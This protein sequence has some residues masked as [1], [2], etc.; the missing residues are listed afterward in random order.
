MSQHFFADFGCGCIGQTLN[1]PST[2]LNFGWSFFMSYS[3][4]C[5]VPGWMF[6]QLWSLCLFNL[7]KIV[8]GNGKKA[9]NLGVWYRRSLIILFWIHILCS[10]YL[11]HKERVEIVI[12]C[13]VGGSDFP[14]CWIHHITWS[15]KSTS[16]NKKT[17]SKVGQCKNNISSHLKWVLVADK[18]ACDQYNRI[19]LPNCPI[20]HCILRF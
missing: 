16:K 6:Q 2:C 1:E 9:M 17:L 4:S 7:P 11:S 14:V 20:D 19:R 5:S 12:Y 10:V 13:I 3:R 15:K 18:H 8:I